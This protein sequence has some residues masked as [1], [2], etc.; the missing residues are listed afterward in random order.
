VQLT[1]RAQGA[2]TNFKAEEINE[3]VYL[4]WTIKQGFTCNGVEVLRSTDSVNF[5]KVGD[6]EGICG[7]TAEE[8]HYDFTDIFPEKNADNFYRLSLGGLGFS[9]IISIRVVDLP[10][11]KYLVVP[12]PLTENTQIFFENSA[13]AICSL[14]VYDPGGQ[15]LYQAMTTGEAFSL[16]KENFPDGVYFFRISYDNSKEDLVGRFVAY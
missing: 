2:V 5:V 3:N 8:I 7:S 16:Q 1:V 11:N 9:S 12:N 6:I 13:F 10:A 4:T 15:P 14:T